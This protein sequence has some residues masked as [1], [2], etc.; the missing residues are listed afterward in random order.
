MALHLIRED[1]KIHN[2]NDDV[3]PFT[4]IILAAIHLRIHARREEHKLT[5]NE[6][7]KRNKNG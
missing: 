1:V 6:E 3:P 7:N 2:M 5:N 4:V